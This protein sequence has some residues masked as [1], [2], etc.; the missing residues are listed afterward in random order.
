MHFKS[1]VTALMLCAAFCLPASAQTYELNKF[2]GTYAAYPSQD[3]VGLKRL[4]ITK[5]DNGKIKFRSTLA[6]FPDDLYLGEATPESYA[7]RT[8]P[9]AR[10]YLADFSAGK[11][12]VVLV[13][14]TNINNPQG[15]NV[16]SYMKYTDSSKPS[17][18][19]EG[20]LQKEPEKPAK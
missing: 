7:L 15:I 14:S 1:F 2:V 4:T 16:T 12:S 11:L 3:F 17:V 10:N 9:V 6:G 19:F 18:Y 8:N 5:E 20:G 13:V